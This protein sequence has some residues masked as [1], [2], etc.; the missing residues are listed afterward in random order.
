MRPILLM[1]NRSVGA[2]TVYSFID[3]FAT[4]IGEAFGQTSNQTNGYVQYENCTI[5]WQSGIYA[6][7]PQE[8]VWKHSAASGSWGKL[9]DFVSPGVGANGNCLGL[10]PLVRNGTNILATA[11]VTTTPDII[12]PVYVAR[13]DS[14]VFIAPIDTN[15]NHVTVGFR[16]PLVYNNRLFWHTSDGISNVRIF[17]LNPDTDM[18]SSTSSFNAQWTL[19]HGGAMCVHSGQ[20]FFASHSNSNAVYRLGVVNGSNVTSKGLF[21]T[22]STAS[23]T[24]QP[25]LMSDGTDLFFFGRGA[26]STAIAVYRL[27]LNPDF[28]LATG[29][30]ITSTV[31]P[32]TTA[33]NSN[34]DKWRILTDTETNPGSTDR[35]IIYSPNAST[36]GIETSIYKWNGPTQ[37]VTFMGA[38]ADGHLYSFPLD[39]FGGGHRTLTATGELSWTFISSTVV[40]DT[41]QISYQLNGPQNAANVGLG[42]RY[43]LDGAPLENLATISATSAG[44]LSGN[45][46]V[47]LTVKNADQTYTLTWEASQDGLNSESMPLVD[48]QIFYTS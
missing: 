16:S 3:G 46:V 31:M 47:G 44:S 29:I 14:N 24:L 2:N 36:S 7:S 6:L 21:G 9:V 18:I 34:N 32:F 22:T 23:T 42:L 17:N 25:A 48:G 19:A 11:Y 41:I 27:F 1:R 39:H 30:D 8:G 45:Y 15:V 38:G 20:L 10:Y 5:N 40:D 35:Y 13:D 43:S 37:Q 26:S 28:T 4:Q 12:R 33:T